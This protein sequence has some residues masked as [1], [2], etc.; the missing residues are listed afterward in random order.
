MLNN[1]VQDLFVC[2]T[3]IG[4][5]DLILSSEYDKNM[6]CEFFGYSLDKDDSHISK[7]YVSDIEIYRD[8]ALDGNYER[9]AN[10]FSCKCELKHTNSGGPLF[11]NGKVIGMIIRCIDYLDKSDNVAYHECVFIKAES[12]IHDINEMRNI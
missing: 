5:S 3:D 12:I 2:E 8:V 6:S 7:D 11:Q 10:C 9:L 1:L 4:G